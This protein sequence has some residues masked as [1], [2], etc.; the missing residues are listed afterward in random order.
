MNYLPTSI[1]AILLASAFAYSKLDLYEAI[2][3]PDFFGVVHIMGELGYT[4]R[5]PLHAA[6]KTNDVDLVN[7]LLDHKI[8]YIDSQN[9][10]GNTP[11]YLASRAGHE[12][13][14]KTLAARGAS[15]NH[16]NSYGRTPLM[17]AAW[18][19]YVK[20]A[21]AL[22][23]AHADVDIQD[24]YGET[25]LHEAARNNQQTMAHLLLRA[26]ADALVKNLR[27]ETPIDIARSKG[28]PA[29]VKILQ[30]HVPS[31]AVTTDAKDEDAI[32]NL[33]TSML[34]VDSAIFNI[35]IAVVVGL[36]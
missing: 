18:L 24:H 33:A 19:G 25:A 34:Y 12:E 1:L 22:M 27:G 26:G 17:L 30:D 14:V 35:F 15:V 36:L 3:K 11:I 13:V 31:P 6:S 21:T 23:E 16:G 29:L 2:K 10:A 4:G 20:V 9:D 8:T 7:A 5:T 32:I 28:Y